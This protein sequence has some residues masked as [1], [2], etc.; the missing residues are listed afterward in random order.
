MMYKIYELALLAGIIAITPIQGATLISPELTDS[1]VRTI[2]GVIN[3]ELRD[4]ETKNAIDAIMKRDTQAL[5]G[6]K[7]HINQWLEVQVSMS[8]FASDPSFPKNIEFNSTL[9]GLALWNA[10]SDKTAQETENS[11]E[12]IRYLLDSGA[13]R[14]FRVDFYIVL[15]EVSNTDAYA[16]WTL[17]ELAALNSSEEIRAIFPWAPHL[18]L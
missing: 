10:L 6:L 1:T 8:K 15:R 5:K 9:L 16:E 7:P 13:H 2:L 11:L 18:P 3:N 14:D 12:V 4:G 17:H